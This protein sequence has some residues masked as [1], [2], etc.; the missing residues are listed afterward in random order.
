VLKLTLFRNDISECG[1]GSEQENHTC[2]IH[3]AAR[4]VDD[5][6]LTFKSILTYEREVCLQHR[7]HDDDARYWL[8]G[9]YLR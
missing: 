3:L 9:Y 1:P 8:D 7:L 4:L 6:E 5:F 2:D